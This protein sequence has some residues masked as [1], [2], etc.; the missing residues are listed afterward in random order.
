MI[1]CAIGFL[2][3]GFEIETPNP[4]DLQFSQSNHSKPLQQS[5]SNIVLKSVS[6]TSNNHT[7]GYT[8]SPSNQN[9]SFLT[10]QQ[11]GRSSVIPNIAQQQQNTRSAGTG[12][13]GGTT[14]F[15]SN[16]SKRNRQ[17]ATN[18]TQVMPF[19]MP[20][21]QGLNFLADSRSTQSNQNDNSVSRAL[22]GGPVT[23]YEPFLDDE[24][25]RGLP[26]IPNEPALTP[27]DSPLY[28]LLLLLPY[29]AFKWRFKD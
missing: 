7:A 18:G 27:I 19:S 16:K 14:T 29:I 10:M 26:N 1:F 4:N 28:L 24:G 6:S 3:V 15:S 22:E 21:L 9:V 5:S 11:N 12:G 20:G 17:S 13:G 25:S 23:P 8:G 2:I